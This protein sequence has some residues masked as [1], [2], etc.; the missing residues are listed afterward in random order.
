[1][2][3][4]SGLRFLYK[5]NNPALRMWRQTNEHQSH[6]TCKQSQVAE[7]QPRR[8]SITDMPPMCRNHAMFGFG[9]ALV[10]SKVVLSRLRDGRLSR[11]PVGSPDVLHRFPQHAEI[12]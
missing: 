7:A 9:Q 10:I 8:L 2:G 4:W 11:G 1:M 3:R 5:S 6:A 12:R